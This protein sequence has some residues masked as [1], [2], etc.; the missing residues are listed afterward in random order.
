MFLSLN[1]INSLPS[2]PRIGALPIG[3][4]NRCHPRRSKMGLLRFARPRRGNYA[5][6][7]RQRRVP[8]L[9]PLAAPGV[10]FWDTR[11]SVFRRPATVSSNLIGPARSSR[12]ERVPATWMP[13]RQA[14]SDGEPGERY[15]VFRERGIA[16]RDDFSA[17]IAM[18]EQSQGLRLSHPG[19]PESLPVYGPGSG[20]PDFRSVREIA[21]K[22][23]STVKLPPSPRFHS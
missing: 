10:R 3:Y 16:R 6:C 2:D 21:S 11:K 14:L 5:V 9:N 19:A 18:I 12:T 7:H 1:Q 17:T 8:R 20:L 23:V 4:G 15:G 13:V 22:A